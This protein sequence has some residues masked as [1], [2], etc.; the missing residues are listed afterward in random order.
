MHICF[1]AENVRE[2]IRSLFPSPAALWIRRCGVFPSATSVSVCVM[3]TKSRR[4]RRHRSSLWGLR[5]R[6]L[7]HNL[8]ARVVTNDRAPAIGHSQPVAK[9]STFS[10]TG[11]RSKNRCPGTGFVQIAR[12]FNNS[13][14]L[15]RSQR[16]GHGDERR[17]IRRTA[18]GH[19]RA[20][21][22]PWPFVALALAP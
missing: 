3:G 13:A 6:F 4:S 19:A 15:T 7:D 20:R 14:F 21:R 17:V 10:A 2:T 16:E 8:V 18:A 9:Q 22:P 1:K 12:S 11:R 5:L